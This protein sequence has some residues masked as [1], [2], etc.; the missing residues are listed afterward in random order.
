LSASAAAPTGAAGQEM[1][2]YPAAQQLV[3]ER[4]LAVLRKGEVSRPA[5][6]KKLGPF[7]QDMCSYFV[8]FPPKEKPR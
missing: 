2:L 7:A 4:L 3:Q 5:A 6:P 8:L 1:R